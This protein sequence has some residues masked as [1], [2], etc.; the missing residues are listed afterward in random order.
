MQQILLQTTTLFNKEFKNEEVSP[1]Y[2]AKKVNQLQ[3][4]KLFP[5]KLLGNGLLGL[6]LRAFVTR[7]E[8]RLPI[9]ELFKKTIFR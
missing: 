9:D 2:F 8:K 4:I 1:L 3:K 6:V 7:Q 5:F